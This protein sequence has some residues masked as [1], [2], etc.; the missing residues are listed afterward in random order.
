MK[1]SELTTEEKAK[2]G[3]LAYN[4]LAELAEE[5]MEDDHDIDIDKLLGSAYI[6]TSI[7]YHAKHSGEADPD[8]RIDSR[9]TLVT[10]TLKFEGLDIVFWHDFK[11]PY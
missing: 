10:S 7:D 8:P 6:H 3:E 9:E 2:Y 5:K 4:F 1:Y 11:L